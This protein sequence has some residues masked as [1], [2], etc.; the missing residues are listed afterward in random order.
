MAKKKVAGR[1]IPS[2]AQKRHKQDQARGDR[3]SVLSSVSHR[4]GK[5]N[6]EQ[7]HQSATHCGCITVTDSKGS[8]SGTSK[9][10]SPPAPHYPTRN[11]A[12]VA[13]KKLTDGTDGSI[14]YVPS[15]LHV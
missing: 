13:L 10:T 8:D 5:G 3:R 9:S 14:D 4:S 15:P 2:P 7:G 12:R 6:P 11:S 1:Q